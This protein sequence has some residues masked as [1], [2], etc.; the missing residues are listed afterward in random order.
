MVNVLLTYT[1]LIP[2]VRFCAL[3]PLKA[4]G[5]D[6]SLTHKKSYDICAED[7]NNCDV[8][9]MVRCAEDCERDIAEEC[10]QAG[11]K[12]IYV[13]DDDLFNVSSDIECSKYYN[14]KFI[15]EN[16]HKIMSISDVLWSPNPNLIK[17]YGF[18]FTKTVLI[19]EPFLGDIN[20]RNK[21]NEKLRVGFAG[22][23]SHKSFTNSFMREI[24]KEVKM[25]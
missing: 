15:R 17:K 23:V 9:V 1:A 12:L 6:I 13:L 7:L 21:E 24:L 25:I 10:K 18:L 20:A 2:S 4:L 22:S 19:D 3:E 14:V 16:M 11:K 5:A 8:L